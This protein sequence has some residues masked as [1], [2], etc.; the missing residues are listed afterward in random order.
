MKGK[1]CRIYRIVLGLAAALLM[2]AVS[3]PAAFHSVLAQEKQQRVLRVAFPQVEGFTE[4]DE[5]GNRHGIV[6]D[7]LNEIAKYTG[8]KYEYIDAGSEDVINEFINGE[9]DLMGGAYYQESFEEFFAY[10]DYNTG[11]SKSVLLA[12]RDNDSI[13][14]F[15]TRSME[16]RTIGVYD[17]AKENIRRLE[18]FLENAGVTCDIRYYPYEQLN[19]GNLYAYLENGEVDLLLGNG[20]DASKGYR[21]VAEFDSQPHYIVTTVGNKEVLDGL[22][23]AMGKIV[24]CNPDFAEKCYSEN[25]PDSVINSIHLDN[26]EKAYIEQ[27]GTV[28]VALMRGWHPFYCMDVDTDLHDG[29]VPDV[30]KEVEQF[31]GLEF[32]YVY[33]DSYRDAL[34]KVRQGEA[35][36]AGVFLGSNE[37]ASDMDL[38]LT[39]PYAVLNDI[40]ARNKSVSFPSEELVGAVTEGRSMPASIKVKEVKYYKDVS[41]ALQAVNR[42][43]VDFFYGLSAKIEQEIQEH[44]YTN[45]IPNTLVNDRNDV[46]F[47]VVSPAET[48]LLSVLNKAIN[49]LDSETKE[50]LVSQNIMSVGIGSFSLIDMIYADPVAFVVILAVVFLI[51]V[52]LV[53]AVSRSRVRS[54]RMQSSLEKAEAAN[55]AK[56]E[57]LSRMSHEI[58]TPM[59]AIMGLSDLTCM[60]EN[61]PDNVRENLMKIRSSSRYLLK[62]ISDILDMSRIESGRMEIG[63]EPF[64]MGQIVD[65]LKSMMTA[66]AGRRGLDFEVDEEFREDNLV[67]D[68]VRLKQV[69]MNLISNAFKFTPEGG[70]VDVSVKE[71]GVSEGKA[72]FSF[73]VRDNGPG[74]SPKDQERIFDAFE[75]LGTNHSKSQGTGLGLAISRTIVELMGGGLKLDSEPGKGSVFYFTAAFP[76]G[77]EKVEP[78]RPVEDNFLKNVTILLAEDNDLNAEIAMDLLEMQGAETLRASNGKEAADLFENSPPGTFQAILMDIQMPVMNGLEA[79]RTIRKMNRPDAAAIPIIAMTANS[80]KEDAD[81]AAEAGM[82]AFIT[83][84]VDVEEL[85]RVLR[86]AVRVQRDGG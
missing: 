44:Y 15:D 69:M 14:A 20:S 8:W 81:E 30:L 70:R 42:G 27:K 51:L 80:F 55:R 59:N 78:P 75:Q 23:M 11:Y 28:S 17:R 49:S 45:I 86:S 48:E 40:V 2:A 6:V 3:F 67:G 52:G 71:T 63:S 73:R 58:R 7:Y 16:G 77:E 72:V 47:A 10:P 85:Y 5:D 34:E 25:F 43:Q 37:D 66:E 12:R 32:T 9:Y 50:A 64:S 26:E 61:V 68:A 82:N 18:L 46:S 41:D 35:D 62:L 84:P 56:G 29:L 57:F 60:L 39:S 31:T 54:A 53:L 21:V 13:K 24:D 36:M 4:T 79:C 38:A 65:E 74:I 22:N 19:D 33:A 83:K 76:I 1:R